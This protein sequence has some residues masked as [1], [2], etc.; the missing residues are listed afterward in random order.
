MLN[1]EKKGG[2]KVEIEEEKMRAEE[3]TKGGIEEQLE[4]EM[5]REDEDFSEST[6]WQRGGERDSRDAFSTPLP[7]H[8]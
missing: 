6:I 3:K 5:S 7:Q 8:D 1:N 4:R 2:K